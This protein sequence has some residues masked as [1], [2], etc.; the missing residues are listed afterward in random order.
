MRTTLTTSRAA[1]ASAVVISAAGIGLQ[2][3]GHVHYP[4]VPPALIIAAVALAL[5]VFVPWRWAP[6][7]AVLVGVGTVVGGVANSAWL[8]RMSG[9]GNAL[10]VSGTWVQMSAGILAVIAGLVAVGRRTRPSTAA[11]TRTVA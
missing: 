8:H 2:I 3:A 1:A 5:T 7:A 6:F 9:A 10:S 4:T 11:L